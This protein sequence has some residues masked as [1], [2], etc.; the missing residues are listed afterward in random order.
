[1]LVHARPRSRSAPHVLT[2]ATGS[3]P[4]ASVELF[5]GRPGMR[6]ALREPRR[7]LR[8]VAAGVYHWAGGR[9]R[10]DS[11]KLTRSPT[12]RLSRPHVLE[13]D[14]CRHTHVIASATCREGCLVQRGR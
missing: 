8:R 1:M 9:R 2:P 6:A 7:T 14:P 13:L 3:Y 11:F 10:E 5:G 4:A 12:T